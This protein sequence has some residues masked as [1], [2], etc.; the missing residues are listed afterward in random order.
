MT[1]LMIRFC[2]P[3][4]GNFPMYRSSVLA[5]VALVGMFALSVR[6]ADPEEKMV[7]TWAHTTGGKTKE[8][9]TVKLEKGKWSVSGVYKNDDKEVGSYNGTACSLN[10]GT[11]TFTKSFVKRP[12]PAMKDGE[13]TISFDKDQLVVLKT[14]K[15]ALPV[16]YTAVEV[17]KVEGPFTKP[18][19]KVVAKYGDTV[20]LLLIKN[21]KIGVTDK[22]IELLKDGKI[23]KLAA[24]FM[25]RE[26]DEHRMVVSEVSEQ[27]KELDLVK[28]TYRALT[29]DN[30]RE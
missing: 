22:H 6:G 16:R 10:G 3:F 19:A 7:G 27:P 29:V 18:D 14:V 5:V 25:D 12:N 9:L 13:Y 2:F 23:P 24:N 21:K 8:F 4:L 1:E 20:R 28:G 30:H 15:G 26:S 11:L 17:V